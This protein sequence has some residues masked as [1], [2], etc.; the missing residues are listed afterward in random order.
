[1]TSTVPAFRS[2]GYGTRVGSPQHPPLLGLISSFSAVLGLSAH[3]GCRLLR[4]MVAS[5]HCVVLGDLG[6]S[7]DKSPRRVFESTKLGR[8]IGI[9]N[10]S[11]GNEPDAP[12]WLSGLQVPL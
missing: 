2:S 1:M 3:F 4:Y 8:S 10:R 12:C 9:G 7:F 11:G 6:G 5:A